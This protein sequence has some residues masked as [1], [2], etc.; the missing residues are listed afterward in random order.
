M[1]GT[2][3]YA[4]AIMLDPSLDEAL[5][6]WTER[7]EG[8]TWDETGGHVTVARLTCTAP[9]AEV[10]AALRSLCR[11]LRPLELRLERPVVAPYWGKPGLWI[12]MLVA[13]GPPEARPLTE[14]RDSLV[15]GLAAV[16]L[17]LLEEG[18]FV[19]HLTLTT[20]VAE[21]EAKVLAAAAEGLNLV[22]QVTAITLWAGG[23][24][25][26]ERGDAVPPWAPL[27]AISLGS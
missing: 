1:E 20:G 9:E 6:R 22:I 15:A 18:Q 23:E 5:R 3:G 8:A 12:V 27:A 16:G 7:Q 24:A 21:D 2:R 19:P 4:L 13:A 17:S 11:D 26:D 10:E 14:L 25:V